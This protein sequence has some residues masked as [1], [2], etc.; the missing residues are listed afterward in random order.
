M[1]C[2]CTDPPKTSFTMYWPTVHVGPNVTEAVMLLQ[3]N[4]RVGSVP[5]NRGSTS[6]AT[7]KHFVGSQFR[8]DEL[9]AVY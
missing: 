9:S 5:Y 7:G 4:R 2:V 6:A 3:V 8:I 1:I